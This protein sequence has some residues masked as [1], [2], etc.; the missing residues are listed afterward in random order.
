VSRLM[1]DRLTVLQLPLSDRRLLVPNT[2]LAELVLSRTLQPIEGAP[3][4]LLGSLI[5]RG[6]SLPLICFEGASSGLHVP[7]ERH[8]RIAVLNSLSADSQR[9]F[10]AVLLQG[11]PHSLKVDNALQRS[12][13]PLLPLELDAVNW[14]GML[15]KVPDFQA[16]DR[17]LQ[18]YLAR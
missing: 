18:P 3:S 13:E 7:L 10:I 1:Q 16:L 9:R 15:F 5:W 12:S 6:L 11:I 8:S 4:W 2:A 14:Q 17:L